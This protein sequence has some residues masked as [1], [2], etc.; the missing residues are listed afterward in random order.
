MA[1]YAYIRVSTRE[2]NIDRQLIALEP[3]N[4]P[5]KHGI[6]NSTE[7]GTY[8]VDGSKVYLYKNG[9]KGTLTEYD[10]SGNSLRNGGH[11][12]TKIG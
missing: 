6:P 11:T 1:D 2:Q 12:I 3:Y 7:S 8:E 9:N 10:Y 4:I 5:K